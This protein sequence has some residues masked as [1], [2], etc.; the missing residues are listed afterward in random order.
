[1]DLLADYS[2]SGI[3]FSL[4]GNGGPDCV[5]H[6]SGWRRL[7]EDVFALCFCSLCLIVGLKIHRRPPTRKALG[8]VG[9]ATYSASR[10]ALLTGVTFAY[11]MEITYKLA[12]RQFVFV[13]NPCH[14]MCL[15]QI[16][17][18]AWPA[19]SSALTYLFRFHL[20]YMHGPLLAVFLP[21]TNTL[22]L[23]GEVFTYWFEHAMIIVIPLWLLRRGANASG[24]LYTVEPTSDLSWPLM[25]YGIWGIFHFAFLESVAFLTQANLNSMLCPAISDPFGGQN[26]RLWAL[27]HQFVLN[28]L[29]GKLFSLWGT[30]E[31]KVLDVK[32][33]SNGRTKAT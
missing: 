3:D 18:L 13:L 9:E 31:E 6:L 1:M 27:G 22:F 15:I 19:S 26:W 25:S 14:L 21:V 32:L 30:S 29:A 28:L 4:A 12:T 24:G 5:Y 11:G 16:I 17:L 20:S 10:L 2:V 23:P 33:A 8:H 7:L